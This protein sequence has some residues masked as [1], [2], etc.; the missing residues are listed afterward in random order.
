MPTT[1]L[2][3]AIANAIATAEGFFVAGALPS[4]HNNP[5]DLRAAPWL[6]H[7]VVAN[8]F[9]T[10]TSVAQGVSGLLHQIALDIARGQNLQQLITSWAPPSD[11]NNTDNYINE[12]L[13]R[14]KAQ[15]FDIDSTVPLQNYL[16]VVNVP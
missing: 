13:R 10:A 5:G 12:T 15:G 11:G 6:V 16:T 4:R 3:E 2:I 1:G 14:L 8:G 9:W 7:P